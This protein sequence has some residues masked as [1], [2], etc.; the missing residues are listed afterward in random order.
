MKRQQGFTLIE[1]V[2]VII[3]LGIIA[4]VAIPKYVNLSSD[5]RAALVRD[6]GGKLM[7]MN[8]LVYAKSVI[9]GNEEQESSVVPRP[10]VLNSAGELIYIHEGYIAAEWDGALENALDLTSWAGFLLE[11]GFIYIFPK[12]WVSGYCFVLYS[13]MGESVGDVL[14]KVYT[15]DC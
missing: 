10:Y 4:T 13:N 2:V 5:A 11:V 1:L 12:D 14:I 7:S 15:D 9:A 8:D 6:M 3:I